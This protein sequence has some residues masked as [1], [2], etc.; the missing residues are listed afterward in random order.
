[1]ASSSPVERKN[2]DRQVSWDEDI[3]NRSLSCRAKEK[4]VTGWLFGRFK[5]ST[6]CGEG[7]QL[8]IVLWEAEERAAEPSSSIWGYAGGN[9]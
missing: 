9:W 1:M 3:G 6:F 7:T 5:K 4:N 8:G 2:I